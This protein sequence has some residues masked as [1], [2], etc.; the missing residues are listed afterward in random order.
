MSAMEFEE[1]AV[2]F[3]DVLG[4]SALVQRAASNADARSQLQ[5]L[6]ELLGSEMPRLSDAIDKSVP[7]PAKPAFC[8]FS[9]SIVLSA[10]CSTPRSG[11]GDYRGIDAVVMRTIQ[12]AQAVLDMGYLLRGGVAVGPVWHVEN[13]VVGV[14]FQEAVAI[15]RRVAKQARVVL[16]ASAEAE[17]K[18]GPMADSQMCIS[19]DGRLMANT[20]FEYYMRD[21]GEHGGIEATFARWDEIVQRELRRRNTG[22][23]TPRSWYRTCVKPRMK[24]RWFGK[25]LKS[26]RDSI[27]G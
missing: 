17:W 25:Y 22:S 2:A 8:Y 14:A 6:V 10:P 9:D 12:L 27:G 24:W 21:A 19:Y 1:R 5:S 18:R 13:N 3:L 11:G 4:F 15:E 23:W 16:S 26:R 20:L 7:P